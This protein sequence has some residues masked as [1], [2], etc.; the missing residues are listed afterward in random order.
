MKESADA[1][2][3]AVQARYLD[4][5]LPASEPLLRE[6]EEHAKRDGVPISDPEVGRLLTMLVR[7]L[8]AHRVL[9][10]GTAIGY[11]ALC[12]ARGNDHVHVI[13]IEPE[14]ERRATARAY[15][16]RAGVLDRVELLEGK[17]LTLIGELSGPY[18]LA[19]VDAVKTEYRQYVEKILPR[20][21]PG[22]LL[23]LDN[24]LWKGRVAEPP[25]SEVDENADAL[26]DLNPWLMNHPELLSLV[27][28]LGDGLGLAVKSG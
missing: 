20:L 25:N 18:D 23:V 1:L 28:P 15:L 10:V 8:D 27:L 22:G 21:R 9:E 4:E 17:G 5:L 12:L 7:T 16:G 2:L 19:Y 14:E 11:G 13:T 3:H 26:R 24:L 6:M